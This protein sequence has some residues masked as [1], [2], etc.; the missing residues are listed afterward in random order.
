MRL[1]PLF[2]FRA[3]NYSVVKI[4]SLCFIALATIFFT[5][6]TASAQAP[7]DD[8]EN[9]ID[10]LLDSEKSEQSD[11]IK[12]II[13][14]NPQP[15]KIEELLKSGRK[16]SNDI[17]KGWHILS[18]LCKDGISRPFHVYIPDSYDSSKKLPVLINLHGGVSK[19]Q[20]LPENVVMNLRT[21]WEPEAN[22]YIVILPLGQRGCS[23]WDEVGASAILGALHVVASIYNIDENRIYLSGFSD[24]GS[25][26]YY[27][28]H[29]HSTPFA[30][31]VVL[32]GSVA[33]AE[34]GGEQVYLPS[35]SNKP[36][37]AV[38]GGKDK[39]YP[40]TYIKPY[41]DEMKKA[42]VDVT[43]KVYENARHDFSY[44]DKEKKNIIAFLNKKE[45]KPFPSKITIETANENLGRIHYVKIDRIEDI[46]N[47]ENFPDYNVPFVKRII[48][49]IALDEKFPGPGVRIDDIGEGTF[50]QTAG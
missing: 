27:M 18:T 17:E 49:G 7:N 3:N 37:Y 42:G 1:Y 12:S 4:A 8:L 23:W 50:A 19:P 22:N 46:N 38:S 6:T 20:L 45:R 13:G 28:A 30:A 36:L 47:N 43:Y 24:G 9:L 44:G 48:I 25:G 15:E 31:F 40:A 39:L 14:L 32:N 10:K 33:V 21:M 41:I 5:F 35:F 2:I 29:C 34:Q 26:T 16:Y 11:I